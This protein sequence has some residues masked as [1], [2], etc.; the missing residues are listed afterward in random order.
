MDFLELRKHTGDERRRTH[1]MITAN[2]IPDL[3]MKRVFDDREWTLFSPSDVPELHDL[4]GTA[5]E[6][7]YEYYEEQT[8]TGKLKFFKR[9]KAQALWRKILG[10]LFETGHPAGG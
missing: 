9:I 8:R 2:W 3:F 1:D 6:E 4:Y 7:R 5:F 10:M